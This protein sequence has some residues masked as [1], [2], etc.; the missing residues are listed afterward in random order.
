MTTMVRYDG[1][2]VAFVGRREAHL[3]PRIKALPHGHPTLRI[4]VFMCE[5][6]LAAAQVN[7]PLTYRD[8]DAIEYARRKLAELI[9]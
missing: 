1:E 8:D 3:A 6:A 7:P 9:D 2:I 4:A 5:Y